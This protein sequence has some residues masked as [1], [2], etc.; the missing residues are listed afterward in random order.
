LIEDLQGF[1]LKRAERKKGLGK[2]GGE[3]EAWEGKRN[4]WG[5]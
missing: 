1:R 2:R 4:S 5:G 3:S